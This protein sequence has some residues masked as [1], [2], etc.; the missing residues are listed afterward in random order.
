MSEKNDNAGLKQEPSNCSA[1]AGL[2]RREMLRNVGVGAGFAAAAVLGTQAASAQ[3]IAPPGPATNPLQRQSASGDGTQHWPDVRESEYVPASVQTGYDVSSGP[4]WV[5]NSGRAFG[6][7]PMDETSR[8]IVE[9]VYQYSPANFTNSLVGVIGDAMMDSI[10]VMYG[11]FESDPARINARLAS[12]YPGNCTVMGYGIKT[13][14]EMAAFANGCLIRHTDFNVSSHNTEILG[15]ILAVGEA[16]HSS[17]EEVMAALVIAYEVIGA[18]TVAWGASQDHILGWESPYHCIATAMA[19]GK[20][21]KLNQDQLANALSLAITPHMAL[22][23]H[24]GT[25][26]MWKGSHSSE[27]VKNGT[28]AALLARAGFTC[29]SVPFEGRDGLLAKLGP[30]T[31]DLRF[32]SGSGTTTIETMLGEYRGYKFT[33][34]EGNTLSFHETIA[35]NVMAWTKPEEIASMD[36][37][38][39]SIYQWQEVC[40]PPKWDPRNRETADHSM[41]YNIARHLID[42]SIYLDSFTKDKY[43]DPK[44]RDLMNKIKCH[45]SVPGKEGYYLIVR[46]KSGEEK[47][48]N[49]TPSPNRTRTDLIAKYNKLADWGG[50]NRDQAARAREQ[51]SNLRSVKDIGEAIQTVAKFGNPKPLSDTSPVRVG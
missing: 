14:E 10:G 44:A 39:N 9:W 42:G 20:L 7:G 28:W 46:K 33:S 45:P 47:K 19:C 3:Q 17:G 4:G 6:N 25:A 32:P 12:M 24:I 15:G 21:M 35:P 22:Y 5:N 37:Y 26:S 36:F 11:A 34:S 40:D 50:I 49:N 16:N 2:G 8:R 43:M 1:K 18:L 23:S 29:W 51:W 41:P 31:A 38:T 13:T 48:F 27:S 30:F